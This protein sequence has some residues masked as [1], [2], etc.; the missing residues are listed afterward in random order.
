MTESKKQSEQHIIDAQGEHLLRA[1]LPRHW[2]LRPYRPDYGLDFALEIFANA[3]GSAARSPTYETLG[4]H[5]FIQLK[6]SQ[7]IEPRPL[8]IYGRDN[9]EKAREVLHKDDLTGVLETARYSIEAPELVTVERMGVGVPVLLVLADLQRQLCYFVC[10]ND[11]VDKILVPRHEN[12]ASAR[13]RTIHVPVANEIGNPIYGHAALRWYGKRA[14][15]YAAFQRFIFQATELHR[16][17]ETDEFLPMA[18]Y[19]GAKIANYDFWNDTEQWPI[20]SFYGNAIQR[21]LSTG[22]PGIMNRTNDA[23]I[24]VAGSHKELA[25]AL[26]DDMNRREILDLWRCLSVLPRNYEEVQREWFLPTGLGCLASYPNRT[27]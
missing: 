21:F 2:I 24:E 1:R 14:K 20:L 18:R 15:L 22:K 26:A 11:Y 9:I 16:A 19:F 17:W 27:T 10:L 13:S 23:M 4:E 6:S 12:L 5:L 8:T 7:C 3:S 25:R